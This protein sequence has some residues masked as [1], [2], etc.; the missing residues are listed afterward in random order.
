MNLRR[1]PPL[2]DP[3]R[4]ERPVRPDKPL[5]SAATDGTGAP[6]RPKPIKCPSCQKKFSPEK[7]FCPNCGRSREDLAQYEIHRRE[8]AE[9]AREVRR[10]W[11]NLQFMV[12][13]YGL[14]L[15]FNF[16]GAYLLPLDKPWGLLA[17][18]FVIVALCIFWLSS[19][20]APVAW[21]FK[22][23]KLSLPVMMLVPLS[24]LVTVAIAFVDNHLAIW[25]LGLQEFLERTHG[26]ERFFESQMPLWVSIVSIC[27]VPG[28]FEEIF[29]RGMVQSILESTLS[30][31]DAWIVQAIIFAIAHLNPLGF[32]TYLLI[33][34]LWLGWLRN[35]SRSL[36]PGMIAHFTHNLFVVLA[37][38]YHL[39]PW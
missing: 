2:N 17:L 31:R 34:G 29:F 22:K 32:F 25:L 37:E 24:S 21:L 18:D 28:I 36:L 16:V 39:M 27:V 10:N 19:T 26:V 35:R 5:G 1:M 23:G 14:L 4:D 7:K 30:R 15:I 13:L 33:M 11:L 9:S 8:I 3:S 38:R 12:V 6:P 20:T